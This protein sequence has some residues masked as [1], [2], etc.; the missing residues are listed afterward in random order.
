MKHRRNTTLQPIQFQN[1]QVLEEDPLAQPSFTNNAFSQNK[2][3]SLLPPQN[4]KLTKLNQELKLKNKR[5]SLGQGKPTTCFQIQQVHQ[6][7]E[8]GFQYLEQN[9]HQQ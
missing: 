2:R 4:F 7:Q 9:L 3:N 6:Q 1:E 5:A 8:Q